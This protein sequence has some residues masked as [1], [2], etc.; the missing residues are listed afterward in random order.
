MA[1]YAKPSGKLV[2]QVVADLMTVVVAVGSYLAGRATHN[3]IWDLT[4]PL[5]GTASSLSSLQSRLADAASKAAE[6]PVVG[7]SLQTPLSDMAG[8]LSNVITQ[9]SDQVSVIQRVAGIAGLV[10]FLV[11]V[12]V[13]LALWLPSRV[14]FARESGAAKRMLASGVGLDLFAL[15][16]LAHLPLRTLASVGTDPVAAWRD[17]DAEVIGTLGRRELDRLG[18]KAPKGL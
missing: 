5:S 12:I 2:G 8:Q 16:G 7:E 14:R 17:G 11:P 15:R 9:I 4:N 18:V 13:W 3:A 1:L 10:V 6:I